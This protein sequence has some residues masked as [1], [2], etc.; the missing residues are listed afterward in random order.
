MANEKK[1][2]CFE[3]HVSCRYRNWRPD[4]TNFVAVPWWGYVD[5]QI[6]GQAIIPLFWIVYIMK[7]TYF[8]KKLRVQGW[9]QISWIIGHF[10]ALNNVKTFVNIVQCTCQTFLS[11]LVYQYKFLSVLRHFS[12]SFV[13]S[14]HIFLVRNEP[15][16]RWFTNSNFLRSEQP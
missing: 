1:L 13:C 3:S 6:N 8:Y 15:T 2:W 11:D 10:N 5:L 4:I 9:K 16:Y 7:Y 14:G 12:L